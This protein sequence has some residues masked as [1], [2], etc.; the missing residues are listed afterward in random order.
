[1]RLGGRSSQA[2]AR[3]KLWLLGAGSGPTASSAT[4]GGC[5]APPY[6]VALACS[7]PTRSAS[8]PGRCP[9]TQKLLPW[10]ELQLMHDEPLAA[11]LCTLKVDACKTQSGSPGGLSW[12]VSQGLG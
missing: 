9:L 2:T 10:F 12:A 4:R 6:T 7:A 5:S 8:R 11:M 3:R 1:M